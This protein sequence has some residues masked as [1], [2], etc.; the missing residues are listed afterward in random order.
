MW[1]PVGPNERNTA[2]ADGLIDIDCAD[3][4]LTVQSQKTVAFSVPLF[5]S[6]THMVVNRK[7]V[8]NDIGELA[9]KTVVTTSQS[10]NEAMLRY[11]LSQTG[12]K[13]EPI[14]VRTPKKALEL[15]QTGK[16]QALF[17]DDATLFGIKLDGQDIV[18]LTVLPKTYSIRPKALTF[19]RDDE[20]MRVFMLR[21]MKELISSGTLPKMYEQ[22][23]TTVLPGSST[24][25]GV[26]LN[27][28][29]RETWKLPTDTFVDF[30]YGHL[31]D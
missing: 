2:L 6:A 14:V 21:H 31:P 26:P 19:R 13:A 7:P 25:L 27:Y 24:N 9:G 29:L 5:I 16:A 1:I 11:V 3:S 28:L 30:S 15:L 22:W 4:T 8:S 20:K 12:V 23:F 17:A 18:N 10:G